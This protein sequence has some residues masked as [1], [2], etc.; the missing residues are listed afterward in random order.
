MTLDEILKQIQ[1]AEKIVILTHESPDG[2]AVGS[3]LAMKLILEKLEKTAD[4][5]IPEYSRL[6]NFLPPA[7]EIM[8]DSEIKNYDLAISVDCATLK[9]MAKKEYFENAKSTIVID[10]HGSNTMYG[11]LNYV[12][13]AS[14]ACCEVIAGMLKYYEIDITKDI[15]TCLMTGIITD[16]GGF[17]HVGIT[18]E[19]FEFT[20][21]LLRKGVNVS[22]IYQRVLETKT[23]SS[24]ELAR[25]AMNRLELLEDG[26]IAFTYINKKDEEEVNAE[27]GDHEGI[28]ENGRSIEGVKVSVFI[29]EKEENLYKVSMRAGNGSNINVSDICYVFGGGGHPRAAGALIQ[30]TVE[31]AKEKLVKEIKKVI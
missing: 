5:I 18:P 4:V 28:V 11:D 25:R 1:K 3:S 7:E 6:F 30:G 20:A 24:F 13:P 10:H 31:Q 27:A 14:P 19:T 12:N 8:I 16:T 21:E 29:R 2:D 17:R 15:G 22:D 23:K 9:R 26:K